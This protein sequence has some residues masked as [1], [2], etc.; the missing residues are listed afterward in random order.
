MIAGAQ[1]R[2]DLT[3]IMEEVADHFMEATA[4]SSYST[5]LKLDRKIRSSQPPQP[6]RSDA[7]LQTGKYLRDFMHCVW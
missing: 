5:V 2:L 1:F 4:S 7:E 3:K 6:V